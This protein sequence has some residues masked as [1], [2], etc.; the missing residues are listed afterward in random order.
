MSSSRK[1][2]DFLVRPRFEA[3][4]ITYLLNGKLVAVSQNIFLCIIEILYKN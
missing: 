4:A 1:C 2:M 3:S